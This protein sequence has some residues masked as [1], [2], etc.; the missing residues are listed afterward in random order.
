MYSLI[1]RGRLFLLITVPGKAGE[2]EKDLYYER[3]RASAI[4]MAQWLI[5]L[6]A[7]SEAPSLVPRTP[8]GGYNHQ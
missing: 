7:F 3:G 6:A 1:R 4:E 2:N 8:L 5:V